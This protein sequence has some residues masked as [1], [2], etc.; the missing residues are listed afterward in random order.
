MHRK[1]GLEMRNPGAGVV[2]D[3]PPS[4][5]GERMGARTHLLTF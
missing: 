1:E 3:V 5:S 2:K 4:L